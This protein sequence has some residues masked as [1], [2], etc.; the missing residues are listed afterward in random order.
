MKCIRDDIAAAQD[1]LRSKL[2]NALG[3]DLPGV[4]GFGAGLDYKTRT[5]AL[6]V[7]VKTAAAER[8]VRTKL[9][10]RIFGLPIRVWQ[11]AAATFD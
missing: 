11:R 1:E 2:V 3:P 5:P 9:P 8:E 4:S 6:N 10:R 7:S